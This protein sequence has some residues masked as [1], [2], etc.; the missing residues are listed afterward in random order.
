MVRKKVQVWLPLV[1]AGIMTLGMVIGYQLRE[2]TTGGSSFLRNDNTT[3]LQEA[4]S[5]IKNKYASEEFI[6]SIVNINIFKDKLQ[7][8]VVYYFI[9]FHLK[10][11]ICTTCLIIR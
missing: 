8:F 6:Q 1:F 10:Y 5:L 2:N 3:P 9:F 11:L 4:I 7:I